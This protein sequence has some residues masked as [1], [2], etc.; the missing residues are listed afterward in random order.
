[1]NL[2]LSFIL[3]KKYLPRDYRPL[4]LSYIKHVLSE[5]YPQQYHDM[6]DT[7]EPVQ[8]SFTF[9]V[10]LP[11]AN[12][13]K[14]IVELNNARF[15]ATFSSSNDFD[16]LL[17]YN[18][19]RKDMNKPYPIAN[20]NH[21]ALQYLKFKPV[22]K[23]VENTVTVRFLSP[24]VVRK[25]SKGEADRYYI[26][27]D[28]EFNS[29]LNEITAKRLGRDL[30]LSVEPMAP[31]KTVVKSFDVNIRSSLGLYKLSSEPDVLNELLLSGIG[32]R[33][34]EGFGHFEVVSR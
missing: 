32:S 31:K 26:F 34:S 21:M 28:E 27:E 9:S 18:A 30:T 3:D 24:L 22:P 4:L 20:D 15:W 13:K 1:M 14:D 17:L 6:Y 12:F 8:K 23:I 2:D 25:H 33:R 11:K 5:Y 19:F 29:C 16:T 10:A 7:G